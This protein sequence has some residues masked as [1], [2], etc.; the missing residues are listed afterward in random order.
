MCEAQS[1]SHLAKLGIKNGSGEKQESKKKKKEPG[2][3]FSS[4]LQHVTLF[5]YTFRFNDTG[6]FIRQ[7]YCGKQPKVLIKGKSNM[8]KSRLITLQPHSKP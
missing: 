2:L 5:N 7:R 1:S 8:Y 3:T 4:C 6:Q